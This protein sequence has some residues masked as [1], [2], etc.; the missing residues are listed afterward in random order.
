MVI[1]NT[2]LLV[3]NFI[4]IFNIPTKNALL[5]LSVPGQGIPT[6]WEYS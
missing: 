5:L 2:D 6:Q 3:I 1:V 4:I